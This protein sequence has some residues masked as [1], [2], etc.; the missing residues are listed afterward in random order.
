MKAKLFVLITLFSHLH[1]APSANYYDPVPFYDSFG[2]NRFSNNND[3]WSIDLKLSPF[4]QHATGARNKEGEKVPEGDRIGRWEMFG[5]IWD[6]GNAAPTD[7]PFNETNYPRIYEL[8]TDAE[9]KN[10]TSDTSELDIDYDGDWS[11]RIDNEKL[12][13][14]GGINIAM[15]SGFGFAL[16][17][18]FAE[19]KQTP[20]FE[21]VS[22]HGTGD[23]VLGKFLRED[24][25]TYYTLFEFAKELDLNIYRKSTTVF[26]DMYAQAY[27]SQT[28]QFNDYDGNHV[29]SVSPYLSTGI[30]LPSGKKKNQ[31]QQFTLPS[32]HDGFWGVAFEGAINLDFPETVLVNIGAGISFFETKIES[33]YRIPT[34]KYQAGMIPWKGRVRRRLGPAWN[35][36]ASFLARNFIDKLSATFE[37]VYARHERDTITMQESDS[38]RNSLFLPSLLESWSAWQAQTA[39]LGFNYQVTPNLAIGASG[40]THLSGIHVYKT[41]TIMGTLTFTF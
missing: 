9:N 26:E 14:R 27:W 35:L 13:I 2:V 32:G 40:Q 30:W 23:D 21:D 28:F 20:T 29:V 7:K 4:Y 36:N 3:E 16:K 8:K 5:I 15:S 18:G 39:Y 10:I 22:I 31:D 25:M 33:N 38:S 11:V 41:H 6:S 24:L 1:P 34:N 17:G 12:G 19:Y 37:Y